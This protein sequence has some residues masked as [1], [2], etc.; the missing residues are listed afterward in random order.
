MCNGK[1]GGC[2]V[3]K[4]CG[5]LVIIGGLNWGLVGLAMLVSGGSNWNVVNLLLGSWPTVEAVV[6][7]LVGIAAV[8][9]IFGCK[10]KKC[11]ETCATCQAGNMDKPM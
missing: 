10:C 5:V 1:C 8:V 3:H 9:K 6:Y 4:I 11:M 7:V 2:V